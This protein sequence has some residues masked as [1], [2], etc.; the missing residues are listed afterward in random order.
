MVIFLVSILQSFLLMR[1]TKT[2]FYRAVE[3]PIDP[4]DPV[5]VEAE[6]GVSQSGPHGTLYILLRIVSPSSGWKSLD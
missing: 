2:H 3:P 6:T 1:H 5:A 4:A